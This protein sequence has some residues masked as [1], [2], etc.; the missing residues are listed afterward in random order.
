MS[1]N[2]FSMPATGFCDL[3]SNPVSLRGSAPSL[4]ANHIS[5]RNPSL[6]AKVI[7][8]YSLYFFIVIQKATMKLPEQRSVVVIFFTDYSDCTSCP[9]SGYDSVSPNLQFLTLLN[10]DLGPLVSSAANPTYWHCVVVKKSI[11]YLRAPRAFQKNIYFCFIYCTKALD[12]VGHNKLE[13]SERDG[14]NRPPDLP[15]EKPVGRSGSN[16]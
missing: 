7:S 11:V 16:S 10:P 5:N 3:L 14:N 13:N 1:F 4:P 15:L 8:F 6:S 9:P 12:C 2:P